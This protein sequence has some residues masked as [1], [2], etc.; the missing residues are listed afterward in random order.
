M[1]RSIS[2][3]GILAVVVVLAMLAQA[4]RMSPGG[5]IGIALKAALAAVIALVVGVVVWNIAAVLNRPK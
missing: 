2:W 3:V 1:S 4:F 5:R